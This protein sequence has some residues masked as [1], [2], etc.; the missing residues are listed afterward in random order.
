LHNSFTGEVIGDGTIL[1]IPND[2]DAKLI[3]DSAEFLA[4]INAYKS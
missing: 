4:K 2:T 3:L 1:R